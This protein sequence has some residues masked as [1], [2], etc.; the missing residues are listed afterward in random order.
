MKQKHLLTKTLLLLAV[1]LM[2][3]GTAWGEDTTWSHEFTSPEAISNN[4]ITVNDATWN[5]TTTAG[6]GSPTISTGKYSQIYG[7]KFGNSKSA[8]Y[9]SV[10]FST[11][12]FNSYNVKSVTV[13][14]LNNGSKP[15]TLTA[16]Q[17]S[18]T[19]G[20]TSATFG[21]TWTDLTVNATP[22]TGGSLSFTYSVE[23]A[24]Y[25]HH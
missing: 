22:G 6:E 3:V 11:D 16:Q 20:S 14:I 24:F 15:G 13:N 4:S 5:V 12:F 19:I 21:A 17:G 9:G 1:M 7:L 2:G 23:Q 8:Y 18:T 10:T 25:I